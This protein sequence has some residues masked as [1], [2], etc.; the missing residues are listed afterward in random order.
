MSYSYTCLYTYPCP[1]HTLMKLMDTP[2][3]SKLTFL[4]WLCM[5]PLGDGDDDRVRLSP[6]HVPLG[7]VCGGG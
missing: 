4:N 1:T 2:Q 7:G 5:D 3:T 6:L